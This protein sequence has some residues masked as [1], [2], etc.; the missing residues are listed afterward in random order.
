M[1][2]PAIDTEFS[3]EFQFGE[4]H[5]VLVTMPSNIALIKYM[6][7]LNGETNLPTNGS[8][9]LTIP[10]L[11]TK[12]KCIPIGEPQDKW[13][14]LKGDGL[15]PLELGPKGQDRFLKF[16]HLLKIE[17]GFQGNF[18]IESG[19][20]FPSDCGIASS[21]SSFAA[22]SV[23]AY[24]V[25]FRQG[26]ERAKTFTLL[27][28]ANLSRQ[29]SG[30][31]CRSLFKKGAYWKQELIKK[32]SLSAFDQAY[33]MIV[34]VES[35]KKEVSSS[36]AHKM[37][38]SSLLF[39]GR[40]E[41]ADQRLETLF[42]NA[43]TWSELYQICWEEFWDMHALFETSQPNFGYMTGNTINVLRLI[44]NFWQAHQMGPVVTMDAG[45]NIHVLFQKDQSN[46]VHL[47][48]QQLTSHQLS[49]LE[50]RL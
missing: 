5:S 45:A 49:W 16:W 7:K 46:L 48:K 20:N 9:S 6:G 11:V 1:I 30:S 25:A 23:A 35:E 32:V 14:A 43:L 34:L 33:H 36:L 42:S 22:L 19:N 18:L 28:L 2:Y 39:K 44:R 3:G 15:L 37:V 21:S 40:V 13:Q 17:L 41:R 10:Y 31:S 24:L 47:F 12:L 29:G 27:K 8:Y 50:G 38:T 4:N 26:S